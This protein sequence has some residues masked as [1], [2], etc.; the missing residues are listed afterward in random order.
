MRRDDDA[1]FIVEIKRTAPRPVE[2]RQHSVE[3]VG[4]DVEGK[5]EASGRSRFGD[6][7]RPMTGVLGHQNSLLFSTQ[8][9]HVIKYEFAEAD[10]L[11]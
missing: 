6:K 7:K 4:W 2:H 3:G 11:H 10:S 5:L 9:Y 8:R 1:D